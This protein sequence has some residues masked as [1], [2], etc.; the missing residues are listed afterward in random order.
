MH[1]NVSCK[2]EGK[3]LLGWVRH[4]LEANINKDLKET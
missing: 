4:R 3:R 2:S 1:K